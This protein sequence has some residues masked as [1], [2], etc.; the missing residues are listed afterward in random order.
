M[1]ILISGSTGFIGKHLLKKLIEANHEVCAVVR[2]ST[3]TEYLKKEKIKFYILEKENDFIPFMEKEKFDGVIHLASLFLAVHRTE[4][5]KTLIDSNIFFGTLLLE[6]A[7]KSNVSWFLNTGTFWQHYKNKAYSPVNL[8]SATKQA[9]ENMAQYYLETSKINFATIKLSD[10]FGPNDTRPKV[11]NLWD[12]ISKSGEILDMSPG[13]QLIDINYIENIVDG[14]YQMVTLFSKDQ[15]RKL[16]GKFFAVKSKERM[17]LKKL[18]SLFEK[19]TGRKL[20]INWGARE[21]R[22][23]EV[24]VPWEKGLTI[25]GWKPKVSIKKGIEITFGNKKY[26]D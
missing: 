20:N 1:K 17:T 18:A 10:T 2:P 19:T 26:N 23:R 12:K 7:A 11:F 16:N 9:F 5:I 22:L 3:D 6:G 4:D 14:F 15:K 25:P 13:K 24:M 8:Y 21:Y